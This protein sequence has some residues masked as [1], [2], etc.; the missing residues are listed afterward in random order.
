MINFNNDE[1][2]NNLWTRPDVDMTP[3][4]KS[5]SVKDNGSESDEN[6]ICFVEQQSDVDLK[7]KL[8][9]WALRDKI[10]LSALTN[11]LKILA[12][13][14]VDVPTDAVDQLHTK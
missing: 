13:S 6:I 7:T 14:G 10:T 1:N 5:D 3:L 12:E 11:L 2:Y 4:Y 8:R 9:I